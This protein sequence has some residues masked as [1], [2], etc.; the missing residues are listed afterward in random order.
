[1]TTAQK[2]DKDRTWEESVEYLASQLAGQDQLNPALQSGLEFI[3]QRLNLESGMILA[4]EWNKGDPLISLAVGKTRSWQNQIHSR[5]SFLNSLLQ[6]ASESQTGEVV[7]DKA[8]MVAI[9]PLISADGGQGLFLTNLRE[10]TQEEKDF[11]EAATFLLG[12]RISTYFSQLRMVQY[13]KGMDLISQIFAGLN[14][15]AAG[16]ELETRLVRSLKD[17]FSCEAA[18]IALISDNPDALLVKKTIAGGED[19]IYQ[20]SIKPGK[21]LLGVCM[22]ERRPMIFNQPVLDS[23]FD[24]EIDS[25]PGVEANSLTFVPLTAPD[26]VTGVVELINHIGGGF[27][28]GDLEL[29][30]K[31]GESIAHLL[32]NIQ[33][34]EQ[35]KVMNAHLEAS[36]WE[37]VRSRN[38]LRSLFDNLP[39]SLYIID[40]KYRLV[41]VNMARAKRVNT[42]P[43]MIINHLCYNA[44]YK[45]SEPCENCLVADTFYNHTTTNR[46]ERVWDSGDHPLEWDITVYPIIE[47]DEEVPQVIIFERDVTEKNMMGAILI[48]SEKMAAVGQL[49][50]GIAHEI[51]NPLTVVL[52]NAQLLERSLPKGSDDAEAVDL[53]F[54]AGTRALQVVRN[55]LNFARKEQSEVK[56]T[57]INQ[58]IQSA[59][60]ML[61]HEFMQRSVEYSFEPAEHLP[62]IMASQENLSGVWVNIMINAMDATIGKQG[63]VK[64]VTQHTANEIRVIISDNGHGIE[65]DKLKRIFD[66]FYTTKDVG[67]GTGL[68]LSICHRVIKQHGGNILVDS[69]IEVGTTFTI[70]LPAY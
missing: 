17:I 58:S 5:E 27:T 62:L 63:R 18:S 68:G 14:S 39:D 46:T 32:R 47:E 19:W 31:L 48:Q 7:A 21:G 24:P 57:D 16:E 65:P 3:L 51:N 36:R 59:L 1:M 43:R 55:L 12:Q 50:A 40:R 44:L 26:Q 15:M 4:P 25:I 67:K 20:V 61:K 60:D 11:L 52:A 34:T 70:I 37:L 2:S 69:Q 54:R 45:R 30:E 22:N 64:I 33:M 35:L 42:E 28:H 23:R 10:F 6:Q 8:G 9:F 53:I 66:P 29:L 49:A 41:A 38:T 56:P 13:R